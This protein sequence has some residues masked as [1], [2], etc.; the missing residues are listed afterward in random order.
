MTR[1]HSWW[2]FIGIGVLVVATLFVVV[3]LRST[4]DIAMIVRGFV[5]AERRMRSA[6]DLWHDGGYRNAAAIIPLLNEAQGALARS[7][8]RAESTPF[9]R[10]IP[11]ARAALASAITAADAG[12]AYI[13]GARE[14]AG[15]IVDGQQW[16]TRFEARSFAN[17]T[18]RERAAIIGFI[19]DALARGWSARDA[20]DRGAALA[21]R[22]P[23]FPGV[24]FF[25]FRGSLCRDGFIASDVFRVG[26]LDV[27]GDDLTA[28]LSFGETAF[29]FVGGGEPHDILL[30]FL[31]NTEL[32]PGGGFL[33]T[34]GLAR[35]QR[36]ELVSFQT[37]DIYNLDRF[38]EGVQR[39]DPPEPFRRHGIVQYW[40]LRD[41]NWSPDFAAST[42]SILDFYRRE[43]GPGDPQVIV[44]FTPSLVAS[45]L[46]IVGPVTI[47]GIRYDDRNIID[48]LEYQVE[49]GYYEQGIPRPQRKAI[50]TPLAQAVSSRLLERPFRDWQ[51][52][53]EAIRV[54]TRE[55]QLMAYA[56]DERLQ[57][58]FETYDVAGRMHSYTT[59]RDILMAVD[60]NLGAL[61]TDSVIERS[62]RYSIIPE[63]DGFRG[64]VRLRYRNTGSFTW[65]TTRYR[66]YA[67]VYLPPG[68]EFIRAIGAMARDHSN[69]P[70]PVDVGSDLGRAVFGAFVSIEPGETRDLEFE[71]R[72]APDITERIRQGTYI[73]DAQ[74]QLGSI[75]TQLTLN[76]DFG[77]LVQSAVPPEFPA[78]WGDTRYFIETDL[79][80]DKIFS[81]QLMR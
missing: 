60:A 35:V 68:T 31:N 66:T 80:G 10:Y 56:E 4:P 9:L 27:L 29:A 20:M 54:A 19:G 8:E 51:S 32:R 12:R 61:K 50:V 41:A 78:A 1:K 47:G 67:R 11:G 36:G 62:I 23:C 45:L 76:L 55:R 39:I 40:Y 81:V 79:R 72:I 42:R 63:G 34:Y 7:R 65:K 44:G 2:K 53:L 70:G 37:D 26:H 49:K 15:V 6:Q 25:A 16:F 64:A 75:A 74:K 24:R 57:A 30:L 17:L 59:G 71:F 21:A 33:G 3:I 5:T 13:A 73:L 58:A 69:D 28:A 22:I 52:I 38:V 48:E 77:T 43:R 14:I 18:T 46:R